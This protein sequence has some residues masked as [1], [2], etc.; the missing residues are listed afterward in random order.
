MSPTFASFAQP[1]ALGE[2]MALEKEEDVV[3]QWVDGTEE[4]LLRQKRD[5]EAEVIV[6]ATSADDDDD[7]AKKDD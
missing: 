3:V 6:N 1:A 5:Q 7:G 2:K 4:E